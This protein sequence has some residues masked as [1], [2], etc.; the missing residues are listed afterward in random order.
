VS[1]F[2]IAIVL[3]LLI[4]SAPR[5][6]SAQGRSVNYYLI[7]GTKTFVLFV[8]VES[9]KVEG[10]I[11]NYW[12]VSHWSKPTENGFSRS[13]VF[14]SADCF[15]EMNTALYGVFYD[16]LGNVVST[17]TTNKPK[18]RVIPETL[19]DHVFQFVCAS[20]AE[21]SNMDVT[22]VEN[23]EEAAEMWFSIK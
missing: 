22:K 8:D 19:G 10:N 14:Y 12:L 5:D 20:P 7:S 16:K 9:I 4:Q 15:N 1:R 23:T 18:E 17:E 13:R 3:A 11:R 21:R 6:T 2:L